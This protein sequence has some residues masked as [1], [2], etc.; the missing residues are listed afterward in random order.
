M[1]MSN[2]KLT[3]VILVFCINLTAWSQENKTN[4][5]TNNDA[6]E[7]VGQILQNIGQNKYFTKKMDA[8][9]ID[10]DV[11]YFSSKVPSQL[12]KYNN[13]ISFAGEFLRFLRLNLIGDTTKNLK[14]FIIQELSNNVG[15][16]SLANAQVKYPIVIKKLDNS[17][18]VREFLVIIITK[19]R[20]KVDRNKWEFHSK[21]K[22][23]YISGLYIDGRFR[24]HLPSILSN[25]N[26]SLESGKNKVEP[27]SKKLIAR[28]RCWLLSQ[29]TLY[30]KL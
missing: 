22:Y 4:D 19:W 18:N 23:L 28:Y 11:D 30:S 16:F 5:I 14:T 25:N 10:R 21:R 26:L 6:L 13:K 9:F 29:K 15:S 1:F 8:F 27:I 24:I 20:K 2:K 12:D 7:V 17:T 3:L